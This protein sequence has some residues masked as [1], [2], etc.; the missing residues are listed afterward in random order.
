M[1]DHRCSCDVITEVRGAD[2]ASVLEHLEPIEHDARQWLATYR[3]R[4]TA[5]RWLLTYPQSGMQ[6]GGPPLLTRLPAT[7]GE[8]SSSG[9]EPD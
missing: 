5:A 3:C 4:R 8:A 1:T 7:A 6:G 9:S 2:V